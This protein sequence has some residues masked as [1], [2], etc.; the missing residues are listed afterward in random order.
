LVRCTNYNIV[1]DLVGNVRKIAEFQ[2]IPCSTEFVQEVAE[3]CTFDNLKK[4]R[5]DPS[6]LFNVG[7]ESSLY[8]KGKYKIIVI[9]DNV[10]L[11]RELI[12]V[13]ELL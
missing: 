2:N 7:V 12:K 8:R 9:D 5:I 1:Q 10:Y 11:N 13:I 6:A 4:N 3:K